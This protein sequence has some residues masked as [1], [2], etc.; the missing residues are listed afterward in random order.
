MLCF[1]LLSCMHQKRLLDR[2][3]FH[4]L[5]PGSWQIGTLFPFVSSS[6]CVWSE[7]TCLD[8]KVA[9][10]LLVFLKFKLLQWCVSR[11]PP[12]WLCPFSS[13]L[14][15]KLFNHSVRCSLHTSAQLQRAPRPF[16]YYK[17]QPF[18]LFTGG[19]SVTA[20]NRPRANRSTRWRPG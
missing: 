2:W 17:M 15:I 6:V 9:F 13:L 4:R 7:T 20:G 10:W 14:Y 5:P 19:A 16:I 3:P 1:I 18:G 8:L 11:S 12:S